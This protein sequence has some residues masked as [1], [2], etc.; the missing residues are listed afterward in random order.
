[1]F[2]RKIA[3]SMI[4]QISPRATTAPSS[5]MIDPRKYLICSNRDAAVKLNAGAVSGSF[6]VPKSNCKK[7][8]SIAKDTSE[9]SMDEKLQRKYSRMEDFL[10]RR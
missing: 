5:L 7:G 3:V 9:N 4:P 2:L 6:S 8:A 10:S 1:M